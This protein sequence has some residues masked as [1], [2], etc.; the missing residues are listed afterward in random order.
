MVA[1]IS[2]HQDHSQRSL[3]AV[4]DWIERCWPDVTVVNDTYE[5][6]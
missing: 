6:F 3:Q 4:T 5:F 1:T 2:N